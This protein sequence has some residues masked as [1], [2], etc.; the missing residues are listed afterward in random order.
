MAGDRP[1]HVCLRGRFHRL[2][3]HSDEEAHH[4]ILAH[5]PGVKCEMPVLSLGADLE[6]I[7]YL[8][9]AASAWPEWR[10]ACRTWGQC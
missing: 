6:T 1:R 8:A 7:L 4:V 9:R 3:S 10:S 5:N 2:D